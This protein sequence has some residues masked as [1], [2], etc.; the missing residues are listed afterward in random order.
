MFTL[1][2]TD[3]PWVA[4]SCEL[5]DPPDC[6]QPFTTRASF[7][8]FNVHESEGRISRAFLKEVTVCVATEPT[9]P[10]AELISLRRTEATRPAV[11]SPAARPA[12]GRATPDEELDELRRRIDWLPLSTPIELIVENM[13][14]ELAPTAIRRYK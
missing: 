3:G 4:A 5:D 11:R 7:A 6:L 2:W 12:A 13:Q 14:R 9:Q 8:H 10:R 1:D